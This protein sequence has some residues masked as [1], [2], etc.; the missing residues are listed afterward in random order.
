MCF[1]T[2]KTSRRISDP[3]RF[4]EA[5]IGSSHFEVQKVLPVNGRHLVLVPNDEQHAVVGQR[6]QDVARQQRRAARH[7]LHVNDGACNKNNIIN[8]SPVIKMPGLQRE[9]SSS[10]QRKRHARHALQLFR[11]GPNRPGIILSGGD[12][13]GMC[14]R[15]LLTSCL[16]LPRARPHIIARR[17]HF[18]KHFYLRVFLISRT[19]R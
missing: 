6:R 16:R 10:Q 11:S 5:E 9:Q 17:P 4:A 18:H 14:G 13:R 19:L 2:N 7:G 1:T 15:L 8:I 12:A 3:A